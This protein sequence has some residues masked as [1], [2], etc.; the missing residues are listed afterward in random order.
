M[1]YPGETGYHI[2]T[3]PFP[4]ADVA[5]VLVSYKQRDRLIIEKA[6]GNKEAVAAE[7]CRVSLTLTQAETLK[8]TDKDDISIQL[9]VMGTQGGRATSV[10]IV[11]RCGEQF[12]RQVI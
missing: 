7:V 3:L 10:P 1:F 9:N 6:A 5:S 4:A 8:F 2:F 12:H 11:M